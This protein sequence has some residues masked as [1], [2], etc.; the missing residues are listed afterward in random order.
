M[1]SK[2]GINIDQT[3]DNKQTTEDNNKKHR[4]THKKQIMNNYS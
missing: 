2:R 4:K 3:E 1:G